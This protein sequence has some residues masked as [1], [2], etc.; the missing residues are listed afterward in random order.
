MK[1]ITITQ[2]QFVTDFKCIGEACR[3]HCCQGWNITFDKPSV[4]RYLNSKQLQIR[5]TAKAA[6]KITKK[7]PA[8]WGEVIFST[9]NSNCPFMD[10]AK[11]CSIHGILG[12]EALSTTCSTFPRTSRIYKNEIER[13]LNL[14]CPEVTRMLVSNKDAMALNQITD[15]QKNFNNAPA[16][17]LKDKIINL[18]C[19]NIFSIPV[20]SVEIHI[21]AIV[22]FL[23]VVE[24]IENIESGI[25][26]LE[27]AY[28]ILAD[29]IVN[30]KLQTELAG[31]N[32]NYNLKSSIISLMQ[33]FFKEKS[34]TRGGG[35][36]QKYIEQLQQQLIG[37]NEL[38]SF[39]EIIQDIESSWLNVSEKC[40]DH[41]YYVFKNY[42]K[43]KFW[44]QGFPQRNG[45]SMLNNLY[46]I[47]AEFYF[48]KILLSTH[49]LVNGSI[50][51]DDIIDVIYSFHS[52]SQHNQTIQQIFHQHIEKVRCGDDLSL[53][54]LL[55]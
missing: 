47:V 50:E 52:T 20:G 22:K 4:N 30:G 24:K 18:F 37:E 7:S 48:I 1:N 43:Y 13:S 45:R 5:T 34:H 42:F 19:Q 51:Q 17:P 38:C 29:E 21:Y 28:H 15:I 32:Q 3:E 39:N 6:I 25:G 10:A 23:M 26:R 9:K 55:I 16:L 12:A 31:I 14:S 44:Q 46:L 41:D 11:L 53:L 40:F 54:Q 33:T 49:E 36:L 27:N 8:N 35:V 2:P